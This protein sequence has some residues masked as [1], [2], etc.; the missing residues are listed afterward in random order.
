MIRRER[1]SV[2]VVHGIPS[3]VASCNYAHFKILEKLVELDHPDAITFYIQAGK[4]HHQ[5]QALD[6]YWR[7]ISKCPT[8]NEYLTL[9]QAK[10]S[11]YLLMVYKI[12]KLFSTT[13]HNL[14][15]FVNLFGKWKLKKKIN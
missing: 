15:D 7:E 3:T 10:S 12:M 13:G 4:I 2:H 9:T 6:I 11:N 5:G 8:L 1:A 14:H